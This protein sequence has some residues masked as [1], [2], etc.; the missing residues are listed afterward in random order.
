MADEALLFVL[1]DDHP[2]L[3]AA[4]AAVGALECTET[5]AVHGWLQAHGIPVSSERVRIVPA[6]AEVLVPE[7]A[8]SLAV[9]LSEEETV[10]V[11]Q[12]CAP[13]SVTEME[14]ELLA[15][16]ETTQDWETLVHRALGAGVPSPRIARLT[17]LDPQEVTRISGT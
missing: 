13:R 15:F 9:P 7:D 11:Q 10:R 17:G 6:G 4:L 8:E 3:G 14:Y 2:R 12:A 1:P 5:P 16:R